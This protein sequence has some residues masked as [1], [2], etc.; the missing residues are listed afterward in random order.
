M[1]TKI[2]K[3][4]SFILLL[5]YTNSLF[6]SSD[7][8]LNNS[9]DY[10]NNFVKNIKKVSQNV[11]S[12]ASSKAK[13]NNPSI[14][15]E[16][17]GYINSLF[18][19]TN[20][21][22]YS[23]YIKWQEIFRIPNQVKRQIK[24]LD[25]LQKQIE[26]KNKYWANVV[27]TYDEICK[28]IDEE[29]CNFNKHEEYRAWK[30]I[31]LLKKSID[32]LKTAIYNSVN[33]EKITAKETKIYLLKDEDIDK[34]VKDFSME[35]V[36]SC[37]VAEDNNG[38]KWF[39]WQILDMFQKIDFTK[40]DNKSAFE[41]WLEAIRLLHWSSSE[42]KQ[43]EKQKENIE[44]N[45]KEKWIWSDY[46]ENKIRNFKEYSQNEILS[47]KNF[48]NS[49][50]VVHDNF[51]KTLKK[52]FPELDNKEAKEV[53]HQE[54]IT[55][56]DKEYESIIT[57]HEIKMAINEEYIKLKDISMQEDI[58]DDTLIDRLINM[59]INLSQSI[60]TAKKTCR[61]SKKVC[62]SQLTWVWD[63]WTCY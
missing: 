52:I 29:T 43:L 54:P 51:Y 1:N 48:L 23:T 34:L 17:A 60:N 5:V 2:I 13:E 38:K 33:E 16:Y 4:F 10:I 58:E 37:S 55:K 3:I 15:E 47:E 27:L 61:I 30:V 57:E 42:H 22:I 7:C 40:K 20:Q 6:A 28:W 59:H 11:N 56:I 25:T 18:S 14:L 19:W 39:L 41:P 35:N 12:I 63:C 9:P 31:Y 45:L 49:I 53:D 44:K 32:S 24:R 26:L 36:K 62:D 46:S 50:I 8:S 21:E